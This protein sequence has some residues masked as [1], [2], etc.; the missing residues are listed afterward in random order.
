[1]SQKQP[2]PPFS[3]TFAGKTVLVTGGSGGIGR[4]IAIRF[5]AA[6]ATVCVHYSSRPAE[7]EKTLDAVHE[8]SAAAGHPH[9][10]HKAVHADLTR[11]DQVENMVQDVFAKS[12]LDVLINNAGV[13]ERHSLVEVSYADWQ[14]AWRRALGINLVGAANAAYCAGRHMIE[15]GKGGRI[16]NISSRGAFRGEPLAPAYGASKAGLNAMSQSLAQA[17]APHGI[18]VYAIAPGFVETAMARPYLTGEM[19]AQIR[20][21]SPLGRVAT[22]GDVAYWALCLSAPGAEFATGTIVDVNGASYLRS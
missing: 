4:E 18:F 20:G 11:A 15:R 1:M 6:G 22:V 16:V 19:A 10:H 21:Q 3:G 5:A 8:A 2:S 12:G 14:E 13:Y 9:L 7:A 17:L